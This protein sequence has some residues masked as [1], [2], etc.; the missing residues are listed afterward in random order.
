VFDRG[1]LV[2]IAEPDGWPTELVAKCIKARFHGLG[3]RRRS[4]L[5]LRAPRARPS[6][7]PSMPPKCR[8]RSG[9]AGGNC[10]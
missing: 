8:T 1:H 9:C 7:T 4:S 10:N 6:S 2:E 3:Q 5:P